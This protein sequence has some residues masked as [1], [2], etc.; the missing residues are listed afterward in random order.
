MLLD[1]AERHG[2]DPREPIHVMVEL[3]P[4]PPSYTE[5]LCVCDFGGCCRR[6]RVPSDFVCE[7][8][9]NRGECRSGECG[10]ECC[11][12]MWF[13]CEDRTEAGDVLL[14]AG[15]VLSEAGDGLSFCAIQGCQPRWASD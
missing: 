7:G 10:H 9:G 2:Q 8:C 6:C 12:L 15:D 11:R 3:L 14:Q 13:V 4:P 5:G 1:L